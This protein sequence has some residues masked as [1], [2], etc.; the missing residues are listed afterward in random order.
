MSHEQK[1]HS[2]LHAGTGVVRR[3]SGGTGSSQNYTWGKHPTTT[4][5][6]KKIRGACV[7]NVQPSS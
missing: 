1:P 5:I 3:A 6:K 2:R 4:K 7:L